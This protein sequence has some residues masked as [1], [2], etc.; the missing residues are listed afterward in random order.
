MYRELIQVEA[1]PNLTCM[2][3]QCK[4]MELIPVEAI[5]NL[6]LMNGQGKNRELV[7]VE[8]IPNLNLSPEL[9]TK[10]TSVHKH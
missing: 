6:K 8:A 10:P 3:R 9:I 5:P 4:N 2:N 7:A 1:I